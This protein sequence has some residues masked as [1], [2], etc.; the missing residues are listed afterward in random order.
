[1]ADMN[2]ESSFDPSQRLIVVDRS[3]QRRML[4]IAVA[5][6]ALVIAAVAL[7]MMM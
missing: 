6:I 1:M 5:V 3:K 2:R 7:A 4:I